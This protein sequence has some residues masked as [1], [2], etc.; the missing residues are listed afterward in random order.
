MKWIGQHIWDFISRFRSDV[1]V[2]NS[3]LYLDSN[4]SSTPIIRLKNTNTDANGPDIQFE[5]TDN[6]TDNDVLGQIRFTGKDEGGGTQYYAGLLAYIADATAAQ[7]AGKLIF[8]VAEFDGTATAGLVIN[9]DTDANGEIDVTIGAGAG[10]TTTVA[11]GLTITGASIS[12]PNLPTS[13]P[14]VAGKLWRD[15]AVV[16]VSI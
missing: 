2:E 6:G 13:D 12:L 5:K 4:V 16:K 1:Y 3:Q 8:F 14:G 9:G 10:S 7:E 15:G 11:G